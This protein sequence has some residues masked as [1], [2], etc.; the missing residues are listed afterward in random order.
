MNS[1]VP[2]EEPTTAGAGDESKEFRDSHH[3]RRDNNN[4]KISIKNNNVPHS[5][6]PDQ[7][8]NHHEGQPL[9]LLQKKKKQEYTTNND[10]NNNNDSIILLEGDSESEAGRQEAC[11]GITL[12]AFL[13][14]ALL[15]TFRYFT[16][17]W[18]FGDQ[19]SSN[20]AHGS[21]SS[22]MNDADADTHYHCPETI[23]FCRRDDKDLKYVVPEGRKGFPSFWDYATQGAIQVTYD[24]RSFFLN[25]DRVLF[26]SGS[27]H[28]GR[29]T[30]ESWEQV[31]D[32]AVRNGLNMISIYLFWAQM[33]PYPNQDMDFTLPAGRSTACY[34]VSTTP[35]GTKSTAKQPPS[36]CG[37]SLADAIRSAAM[38]GLFV[39]ARIGP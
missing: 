1:S 4:N 17:S 20:T 5:L 18:F 13:L 28:P 25:G 6:N 30:K 24:G 12:T 27:M 31:L 3:R 21:S 8:Q 29:A 23:P 15:V 10:N 19:T 11:H 26:L 37:W 32:Q 34:Q 35:T 9:L 14:F 33:Q 38:R 2:R 22:S 39:H 7:Q 16:A 36:Y